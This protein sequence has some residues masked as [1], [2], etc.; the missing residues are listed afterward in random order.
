MHSTAPDLAVLLRCILDGG[1]YNGRRVFTPAAVRAMTTDQNTQIVF[2]GP[3][4]AAPWGL[5][6]GLRDSQVWTFFGDLTSAKTFGHVGATGT[7][8]WADPVSDLVCVVLTNNMV[9]DGSLLNRVSNAVMASVVDVSAIS[10]FGLGASTNV[11]A[12]L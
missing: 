11:A 5:G 6:F 9:E 4:A 10:P 1:S 3:A 7:T 8:F 12:R 2:P